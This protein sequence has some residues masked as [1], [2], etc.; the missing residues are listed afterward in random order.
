MKDNL[1]KKENNLDRDSKIINI[2]FNFSFIE[3]IPMF[4]SF[5]DIFL[6]LSKNFV[7]AFSNTKNPNEKNEGFNRI[8]KI[9]AEIPENILSQIKDMKKKLTSQTETKLDSLKKIIKDTIFDEG[10]KIVE[11]YNLSPSLTDPLDEYQFFYYISLLK[12][13][14]DKFMNMR[15]ELMKWFNRL[16]KPIAKN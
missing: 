5:T 11:K 9:K 6:E 15:D 3:M 10:I 8:E 12:N 1:N 14:D 7:L 16:P 13:N 2:I 4:I